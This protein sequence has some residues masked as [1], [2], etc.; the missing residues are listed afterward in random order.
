MVLGISVLDLFKV[1]TRA[2]TTSCPG[3][4][5][6]SISQ[7]LGTAVA[8]I[9]AERRLL[10]QRNLDRARAHPHAVATPGPHHCGVPVVR[11]LLGGPAPT[12]QH[13]DRRLA[14]NFDSRGLHHVDEALATGTGPILAL[15]TLWRVG[16]GGGVAPGCTAWVTAVVETIEPPELFSWFHAKRQALGIH[17]VPLG[18]AAVGA[19]SRAVK[20]G[21]VVCLLSDRDIGGGGPEVEFFGER[22]ACPPG[23]VTMALRT[24]AAL[25]PAAVYETARQPC[26]RRGAA[27]DGSHPRGR[28]RSDIARLTQHL[29]YE[30]EKPFQLTPSSGTFS[31]PTGRATSWHSAP[32][33]TRPTRCPD[34]SR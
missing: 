2:A 19:I 14:A 4:G 32:P 3:R 34:P 29:A 18:P 33:G 9:L 5:R 20:Q 27:T 13:V 1:G 7:G 12:A 26:A 17:V 31:P 28:L 16:V 11:T 6:T 23:P 25:L 30:L 21:H 24:G 15:P 10:I 22:R 8:P